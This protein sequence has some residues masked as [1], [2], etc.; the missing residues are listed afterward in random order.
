MNTKYSCD[1]INQAG[2]ENEPT[3]EVFLNNYTIRRI[4]KSCGNKF[5]YRASEYCSSECAFEDVEHI[6]V[7]GV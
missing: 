7:N 4:C 1:I 2:T 6:I 5:E 3:V